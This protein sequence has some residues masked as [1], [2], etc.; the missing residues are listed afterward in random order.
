MIRLLLLCLMFLLPVSA[1]AE[2]EEMDL[3][4]PPPK[5]TKPKAPPAPVRD[6]VLGMRY[7]VVVDKKDTRAYHLLIPVTPAKE[8]RSLVVVLHE[9]GGSPASI[10]ERTGFSALAEKENFIVAYPEGDGYV[11]TW[12]AG[13]CCG[14]AARKGV[15]DIAFM[16]AMIID[17]RKRTSVEK[18]RIYAAGFSNGGMMTY[19]LA[20]EMSST[21]AAFGIVGGAMNTE[22][23]EPQGR[24]SLIIFHALNDNVVNY[25]GGEPTAGMRAALAGKPVPDAPV[26]NAMD[27]WTKASLCRNFP[28]H[29]ER[30]DATIVNYFCAQHRDVRLYTINTGGHSWP[31]EKPDPKLIAEETDPA[32][33]PSD[34]PATRLIWDFFR[35]HPPGE[36]LF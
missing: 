16:K 28:S 5:V 12:N 20:C 9:E 15:D 24:P 19:R 30:E 22:S 13:T 29:E 32:N 34:I 1:F 10:A 33:L 26:K 8:P 23:C 35:L 2:T 25:E 17:I 36:L 18:T 14:Y 7:E 27:F 6:P 11:P 21:F 4:K 31:G 3:P